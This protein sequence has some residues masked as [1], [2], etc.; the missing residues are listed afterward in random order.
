[1]SDDIRL[2]RALIPPGCTVL[3]AVSGGADS[4]CL[5]DLLCRLGDVKVLC[6]HFDHAI[7]PDSAEDA[8]FVREYCGER[9][10]P[11]FCRRED[12]PAYAREHGLSLETAARERRYAFLRETAAREG[13]DRI[14][15]A[16][17][18]GDN[19]ETVLFRLAR[20]TG[21]RG[22]TG[23]PR[24]RDGVVRPLLDVSR[25]EVLRHLAARGVPWREDPSN[26]E[27]GAARNRVRHH[28]LPAL[29][30]VHGGAEKNIARS[31]ERLREDEEYLSS[32]AEDW[33]RGRGEALPVQELAALPRPVAYRALCRWLGAELSADHAAAVFGL[34]ESGPSA[35]LRLPEGTV[36]REYGL[37]LR[38][39]PDAAA[40]PDTALPEDGAV[41]LAPAPY[42]V[43]C[44]RG[45]A[46][47]EIQRS[48]NTFTF[49]CDKMCGTLLV[50]PRREGDRIT[51]AGRAGERRLKKLFSDAKIPLAERDRV[52]VIR[53]GG[54]VLA[55][56][57][58]GQ[59]EG[60]L[61]APGAECRT[62]SI[63]PIS[64]EGTER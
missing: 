23:I 48:F 8:R 57:G 34:L 4:M 41:L 1:M 50:T 58:F 24:E 56:Y 33:L 54:R 51:L 21:L 37:L 52:P 55:V 16:H 27:D 11:F 26:R 19:A 49:S 40:F 46:P 5:L 17:T 35:L 20:G 30:A 22:L 6:A 9:G 10:V 39:E 36:R 28:V 45:M 15:T 61:P 13:A 18:M 44:S 62:V 14:A 29:E 12:V 3:C 42:I 53:C 63:Q 32:L 2:D 43:R 7:R 59:A 31:I 64:V 38:G 25:G 47:E 60:S